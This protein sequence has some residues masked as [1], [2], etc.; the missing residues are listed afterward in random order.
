MSILEN[1]RRA[2]QLSLACATWLAS[3]HPDTGGDARVAAS[4]A[5]KAEP[6]LVTSER[7]GRLRHYPCDDCHRLIAPD[8]ASP[9]HLAEHAA[10]RFA[11]FEAIQ[12]CQLCHDP[13]NMNTLKLL[14]GRSSSFDASEQV[15]GQCHGEKLRDFQIAAHG[16]VV[17]SFLGVKYRYT[18]TECHD[19]HAPRRER[20]VA[21]AAP[22]FPA[23]GIPKGA[24][25]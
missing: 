3:C 9:R 22:P 24:H 21:S 19:A 5:P 7:T 4:R 17:G 23:L 15:C 1:S 12:Q 25:P 10:L 20:V 18:C 8:P 14:D 2:A 11:H 6:T 16:K 13:Q